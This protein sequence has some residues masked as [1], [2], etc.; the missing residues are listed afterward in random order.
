MRKIFKALSLALCL[1]V[2]LSAASVCFAGSYDSEFTDAI[3]GELTVLDGQSPATS[4][5]RGFTA[6]PDGKY[7]YGGILQ[8]SDEK[9]LYKF[10]AANGAILGH[11]IDAD[12]SYYK[13]I[14][15]DDR[16]YVYLGVSVPSNQDAVQFTILD[17]N[18]AP[19][20]NETIA[21]SGKV[22]VNGCTVENVNGTYLMYLVT[23]YGP[24]Y[25][26][27]YDVTD[28]TAPKL[29]TAFGDNGIVTLATLT[30]VASAEAAYLDV[31]TSG[32]IYMT[33][34]LGSGS[35]GDTVMKVSADGKTVEMKTDVEEA[36]GIWANDQ[37]ILVSTYQGADSK[38]VVLNKSDL[39]KVCEIGNMGDN[40]NY[41]GVALVN[42]KIYVSDQGYNGGDR[43]IVSSALNI[44]QLVVEDTTAADTSAT[45][46]AP[47]AETAPTTTTTAAQTS[48]IAVIA[49]VSMLCAACAFAVVKKYA[50]R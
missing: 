38:I 19:V 44:P 10:D 45:D 39:S 23:N 37:Y 48:D 15:A 49:V 16:G 27:C 17:A 9:G 7:L 1:L 32:E 13:G 18:L 28:P 42:N 5:M 20:Y 46:E 8:G 36:Y 25:V 3:F 22:G 33:I 21:I 41:S 12:M 31:S 11:Y 34:N 4:E 47:A 50:V 43:L 30:G 35:K 2:M 26:Y 14:G 29:N 40:S 24:N 6:S